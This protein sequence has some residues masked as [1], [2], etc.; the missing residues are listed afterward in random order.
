MSTAYVA[1]DGAGFALAIT[2]AAQTLILFTTPLITGL[3]LV[4]P[5][6]APPSWRGSC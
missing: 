5:G 4:V 6:R 3:F 1:G 2:A